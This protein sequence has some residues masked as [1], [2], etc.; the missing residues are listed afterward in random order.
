MPNMQACG[1]LWDFQMLRELVDL[2]PGNMLYIVQK[3]LSGADIMETN[4]VVLIGSR[5][6]HLM[7]QIRL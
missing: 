2:L 6:M 7:Q 5:I 3:C 4:V 1:L